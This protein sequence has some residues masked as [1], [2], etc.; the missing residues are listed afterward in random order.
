[1]KE[2]IATSRQSSQEDVV[3][4]QTVGVCPS[5]LTHSVQPLLQ[6]AAAQLQAREDGLRLRLQEGQGAAFVRSLKL[7]L[8][9]QGICVRATA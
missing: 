7:L 1:M 6:R 3:F 9:S 4:L 2:V 8:T 5:E